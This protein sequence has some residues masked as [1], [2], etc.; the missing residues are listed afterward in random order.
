MGE[1][2]PYFLSVDS[3]HSEYLTMFNNPASEVS[4]NVTSC[5]R[6][7]RTR[8]VTRTASVA[9]QRNGL[10]PLEKLPQF[11]ST[12]SGSSTTSSHPVFHNVNNLAAEDGA[13]SSLA[14][15]YLTMLDNFF[16]DGP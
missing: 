1:R 11:S 8:I 5:P 12:L 15:E 9:D 16:G 6:T 7:L 2:A 3:P 13:F 10:Q 4:P 14:S